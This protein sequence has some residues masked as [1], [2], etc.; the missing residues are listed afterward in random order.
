MISHILPT[1]M[2][3][4]ASYSMLVDGLNEKIASE[5]EVIVTTLISSFPSTLSHLFNYFIPLVIPV[6][7]FAAFLKTCF[8]IVK[9][10]RTD[11]CNRDCK[12]L[13][14][15]NPCGQPSH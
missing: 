4:T 7:G 10:N 6:L 2:R 3:T 12:H 1:S 14:R 9:R 15:D 8:G 13:C 11:Q 5:R